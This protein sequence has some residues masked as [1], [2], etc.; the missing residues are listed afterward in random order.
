MAQFGPVAT[1]TWMVALNTHMVEAGASPASTL[2]AFVAEEARQ[3]AA[4]KAQFHEISRRL[5]ENEDNTKTHASLLQRKVGTLMLLDVF[6]GH[7][8]DATAL[9]SRRL[10]DATQACEVRLGIIHNSPLLLSS[11]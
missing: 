7:R 6:M 5:G 9:Y 11:W 4:E 8:L 1:E 2:A 10:E 3:K